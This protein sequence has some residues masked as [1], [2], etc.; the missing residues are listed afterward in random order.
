MNTTFSIKDLCYQPIGDES[1]LITSPMDFWKMNYTKMMEDTDI[2]TTAKCLKKSAERELPCFD[3]IGAPVQINAVL[4]RQGCEN[5]EKCDDC[6]LCR[7]TARALAVTF[8]VKNDYY[9]NRIAEIWEKESFIYEIKEFNKE[10]QDGNIKFRFANEI[11]QSSLKNFI[12]RISFAEM[13]NINTELNNRE[14]SLS[15]EN[16]VKSNSALN[17]EK[18]E[19]KDINMIENNYKRGNLSL[20]GLKI[21]YMAERSIPDELDLQNQQNVG[22]V[23]IS[24]L[25]MFIYISVFMGEISF[26]KFSRVLVALG[27]IIVVILSF[28]SSIA[29]ISF[30]GIK[31]SLISSEVVPFLVLAIGVD[32]M[33]IILGAKDKKNI[34]DLYDHIGA[35]LKEVG[36]SITTAAFG[37]FLAFFVGY[38]TK[39]PALQSFCLAAAFAVLVD[40]F[41]QITLFLAIVTLDEVRTRECR[42]DVITCFKFDKEI[43]DPNKKRFFNEF[44]SNQYTD[45]I[46]KKPIKISVLVFYYILFIL[47]IIGCLNFPLGLDQNTTVTQN[48]DLYNYF[49]TQAEFVD[50]G[51]PAY[52]VFYNI[53]YNNK[54]NLI[55]LENLLDNIAI[56]STV[57]AP[58]FSWFKD[59]QKFMNKRGQWQTECNPNFNYLEKLPLEIQVKE[60]LKIKINS[61]CC[62]E[63]AVCGE[64]YKDDIYFGE[65]GKIEASRFR[66]SHKPLTE[67]KVYVD[68][69]IQTKS[70]VAEYAKN[71]T[72]YENKDKLFD[73]KGEKVH[74]S[75]AFPYSL[76]YVYYDQYLVIRGIFFEDILIALASIF[77]AVQII[78]NI[79]S[80]LLVIC[81]LNIINF[82]KIK[83]LFLGYYICFFKCFQSS[84][85]FMAFK[86]YSRL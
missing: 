79:K 12:S 17:F 44:L 84:R 70:V 7:K 47:S 1:C 18:L 10:L 64:T 30:L 78:M 83:Y 27:G 21:D 49:H 38:L 72:T 19:E 50:V 42:Y 32:N 59:F 71:F 69:I 15:L 67:Q 34:E 66:F 76:F 58:I 40:Y 35:T 52:L 85:S 48:S 39:I 26:F 46:L 57:E 5:N 14:F 51:P 86:F 23:V 37:E 6:N 77:L 60:F 4:G 75:S 41:L 20:N 81:F 28:L 36:P 61:K 63:F 82:V 65:N 55:L 43:R 45:F 80:A 53:D 56:L 31:L 54:N 24:Y 3:R 33:F 25:L 22:V 73:Y 68:S 74:I 16:L 29:L 9:K 62:Q 13:K 2:K 11:N 8:L